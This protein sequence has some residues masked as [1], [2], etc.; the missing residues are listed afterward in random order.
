[1]IKVIVIVIVITIMYGKTFC[2]GSAADTVRMPANRPGVHPS[3]HP[4]YLLSVFRC[5][6]AACLPASP[7]AHV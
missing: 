5:L 6:P 7:I 4:P 2:V 3:V 1:M